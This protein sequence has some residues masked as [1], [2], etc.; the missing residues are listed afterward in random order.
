MAFEVGVFSDT[1]ITD[2]GEPEPELITMM[3]E[4]GQSRSKYIRSVNSTKQGGCAWKGR[5]FRSQVGPRG[6]ALP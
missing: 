1:L 6:A 3:E 2:Q 5:G 4:V